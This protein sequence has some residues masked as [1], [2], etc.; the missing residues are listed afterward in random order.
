MTTSCEIL[1]PTEVLGEQRRVIKGIPHS[2]EYQRMEAA[3]LTA[4]HEDTANVQVA[5]DTISFMTSKSGSGCMYQNLS[6]GI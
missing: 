2:F 4:F 6:F 3:V 5:K 1:H